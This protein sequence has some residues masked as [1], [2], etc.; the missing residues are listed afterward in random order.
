MQ[1]HEQTRF[2][3]IGKLRCWWPESSVC[4]FAY[5]RAVPKIFASAQG[6]CRGN[7][8]D[9]DN[10]DKV[11]MNNDESRVNSSTYIL[12]ETLPYSKRG[13]SNS[14]KSDEENCDSKWRG[15]TIKIHVYLST[16]GISTVQKIDKH[17]H[18]HP[19]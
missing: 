4:L 11:S 6:C 16:K 1:G 8:V 12:G 2:V 19:N 7:G 5:V 14:A 9:G 15:F 3:P 18:A 17:C 10:R 13:Y